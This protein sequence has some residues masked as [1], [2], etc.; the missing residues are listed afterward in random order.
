M[1]GAQ[2]EIDNW[3]MCNSIHLFDMCFYLFGLPDEIDVMRKNF[4]DVE[5]FFV[6]GKIGG[7]NLY[8]TA[9]WGAP[10]NWHLSVVTKNKKYIFD[11]LEELYEQKISSITKDL[12]VDRT[13]VA[14][15]L[16]KPGFNQQV[17]SF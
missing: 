3:G 5:Q 4:G 15:A 17:L 6:S 11:P 14:E 7:S 2:V 8:M 10:G 9:N 16:F 13:W 12:V 1:K